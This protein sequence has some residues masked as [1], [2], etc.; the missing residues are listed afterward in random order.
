MFSL[1][2]SLRWASADGHWSLTASG[3]N[4]TN[5]RFNTRSVQGNQ[6]FEMNVCQDWVS[7]SLSAVYKF[8]NYKPKKRKE[9]DTSRMGY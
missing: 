8:G 4:L 6:H 2:A 9:V 5:R 1:N 7:A 3:Q